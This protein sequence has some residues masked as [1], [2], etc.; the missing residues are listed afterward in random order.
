MVAGLTNGEL[1]APMTYEETMTSEF[2]EAWFQ[3][4]LLPTLNK[5]SVIIMDNARF[6][7]MGKIELLCEEFGHK[8]LPL[9]P[10][11]PEY[12][13]IE[14]TWAHIKKHLKRYYQVAILFTS[15]CRLILVSIDYIFEKIKRQT[16]KMT[17]V[18]VLKKA[19]A[20]FFIYQLKVSQYLAKY[21]KLGSL[22]LLPDLPGPAD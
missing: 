18:F 12:N 19:F 16:L 3:K 1:I 21:H 2:F 14:K 8:L 15:L 5:P 4:F 10:Y 11:S 9:P 7:R 17:F 20:F 6:H 13:P 22:L